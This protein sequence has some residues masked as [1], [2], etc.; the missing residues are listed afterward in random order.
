MEPTREY[1]RLREAL[2]DIAAGIPVADLE[3][4]LGAWQDTKPAFDD[5]RLADRWSIMLSTA[6]NQNKLNQ[7]ENVPEGYRR[8]QEQYLDDFRKNLDL[9]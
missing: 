1:W 4:T 9:F 7:G 3:G 5:L 2:R 6:A 8:S